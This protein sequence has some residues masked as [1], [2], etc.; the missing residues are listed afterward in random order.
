LEEILGNQNLHVQLRLSRRLL[1]LSMLLD[2][3]KFVSVQQDYFFGL[4]LM[5]WLAWIFL[6]VL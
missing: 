2:A 5:Q 6:T 4:V 1:Y 3:P